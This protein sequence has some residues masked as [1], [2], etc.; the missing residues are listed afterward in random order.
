MTGFKAEVAAGTEG[1]YAAGSGA[2]PVEAGARANVAAT[3]EEVRAQRGLSAAYAET[4]RTAVKGSDEQLIAIKESKDAA[5]RA[6][7]L[8]GGSAKGQMDITLQQVRA[9]RELMASYKET[10]GAAARGSDEQLIA[11]KGVRDAQAETDL[12]LGA[13]MGKAE[14]GAHGLGSSLLGLAGIIGVGFGA[15]KLYDVGKESVNAAAQL[16]KSQEVVRSEFGKS[17][18]VLSQ[19]ADNGATKLGISASAADATSARFGLL[20][21]QLGIGQPKAAG[22][23][24]GFEKLVGSI[25][26]MRG[27]DPTPLLNSIVLAAAGNTR[28]LKQLGIVVDTTSEK[29]A[30]F[31]LTGDY[32]SGSLTAQQKTLAIYALAMA[33]LPKDE[34]DA[35][36]HANDFANVQ[37]RLGA[38]WSNAKDII[39]TAL[40]PILDRYGGEFDKWLAKTISGAKFQ[41][42][43]NSAMK[44]GTTVLHDVRDALHVILPPLEG[45]VK[46]VGGLGNAVELAGGILVGVKGVGA[47]RALGHAAVDTKNDFVNTGG[48]I[49]GVAKSVATTA[50][51]LF[52]KLSSAIRGTGA[53]AKETAGSSDLGALSGSVKDTGGKATLAKGEVAGLTGAIETEGGAAATSG[54]ETLALGADMTTMGGDAVAAEGEVATLGGT[55]MGLGKALPVIGLVGAGIYEIYKH[56]N[57]ISELFGQGQGAHTGG[58]AGLFGSKVSPGQVYKTYLAEAKSGKMTPAEWNKLLGFFKE[59]HTTEGL[60]AAEIDAIQRAVMTPAHQHVAAIASAQ[61]AAK[62]LLAD[63]AEPISTGA[64]RFAHAN[65]AAIRARAELAR[66]NPEQLRRLHLA[67]AGKFVAAASKPIDAP[68]VKYDAASIA[69]QVK[70]AGEDP[71]V[72]H[73]LAESGAKLRARLVQALKTESAAGATVGEDERQNAIADAIFNQTQK[74]RIDSATTKLNDELYASRQTLHT[75]VEALK[76]AESDD[77]YNLKAAI[78]SDNRVIAAAYASE[79]LSVK[80]A[81]KTAA[82]EIAA[83]KQTAAAQI[84][85]ANQ[86]YSLQVTQ[87]EAAASKDIT[88]S[89]QSAIT[90]LQGYATKLAGAFGRFFSAGGGQQKVEAGAIAAQY[91]ALMGAVG[92]GR[93]SLSEIA[94]RAD[95]LASQVSSKTAARLDGLAGLKT[96]TTAEINNLVLRLQKG[97][98]R[99]EQFGQQLQKY[100]KGTGATTGEVKALLGPAAAD[101]IGALITAIEKQ[102]AVLDVAYKEHPNLTKGAR[103][104]SAD[105]LVKPIVEITGAGSKRAATEAALARDSRRHAERLEAIREARSRHVEHIEDARRAHDAGERARTA[106]HVRELRRSDEAKL[107]KDERDDRQRVAGLSAAI[108]RDEQRAGRTV[109]AD[110]AHLQLVVAQNQL[111]ATQHA[112]RNAIKQTSLAERSYRQAQ[113]TAA[114]LG[115]LA[116]STVG[117]SPTLYTSSTRAN[118]GT[119]AHHARTSATRGLPSSG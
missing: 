14:K 23:T 32:V 118:P 107:K 38:E 109:A 103:E 98:I 68:P 7:A 17:S 91:K 51:S 13:G 71:S 90:N 73:S 43:V 106:L 8:I 74:E 60:T 84:K 21:N 112:T 12:L 10:A 105:G 114:A 48:K 56:Q 72:S 86:S 11:Q 2:T 37:R 116:A 82:T 9:Q 70:A 79:A 39:G 22:M 55:L 115:A 119:S 41:K 62:R 85:A 76:K 100:L 6:D 102:T 53:A 45:M 49:I 24:L 92:G 89:T 108:V 18:G 33:K 113:K 75:A 64:G 80:N 97:Q 36:A 104:G 42:D 40:L 35:A 77:T 34:K 65:E 81:S 28:G 88:T 31:R 16:Q 111:R 63:A 4:A 26:A 117:S 20:F 87:S 93:A 57:A 29:M 110:R 58:F 95:L 46:D 27:I 78:D 15:E 83:A 50:G 44:A 96:S 99:P 47:M 19:W 5:V 59:M 1:A 25:A 67:A 101:Q 94:N 61:K 69:K 66:M 52:S 54:G 30:Y 3:A